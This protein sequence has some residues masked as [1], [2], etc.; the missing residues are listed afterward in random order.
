[1]D[2]VTFSMEQINQL[3]DGSF[4]LVFTASLLALFCWDL[5]NY[6]FGQG[7]LILKVRH[8]KRQNDVSEPCD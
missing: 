6:V 7:Y 3:L 2:T 5:I 1:M 4:M 8:H